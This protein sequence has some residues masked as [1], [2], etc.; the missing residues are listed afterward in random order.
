MILWLSL[1]IHS[2]SVVCFFVHLHTLTCSSA[3]H[4]VEAVKSAINVTF[5]MLQDENFWINYTFTDMFSK[6]SYSDIVG[7]FTL[8]SV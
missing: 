7:S 5:E 1:R 2:R 8:I 6:L 4:L 3:A